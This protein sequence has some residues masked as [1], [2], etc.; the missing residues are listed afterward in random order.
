MG[1]LGR[2]PWLGST[3]RS[4]DKGRASAST[5]LVPHGPS[6]TAL[7]CPWVLFWAH[8]LKVSAVTCVCVS[9]RQRLGN[10]LK[11]PCQRPPHVGSLSTVPT[12]ATAPP[13]LPL[14]PGTR[15]HGGTAVTGHD[16][17]MKRT[18]APV[19]IPRC[20]HK[21]LTLTNSPCPAL[22][23]LT[24]LP[25]MLPEEGIRSARDPRMAQ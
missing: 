17:D 23:F 21:P 7:P 12:C 19:P 25:G 9:Q 18:V 13:F 8:L 1:E 16:G 6:G 20:L 10:K 5:R 22:F 4:R 2:G 24:V 15:G 3:S 14:L 11:I